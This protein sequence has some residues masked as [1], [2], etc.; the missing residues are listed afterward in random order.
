MISIIPGGL[1]PTMTRREVTTNWLRRLAFGRKFGFIA[2]AA[3]SLVT[4]DGA[5]EIKFDASA[6]MTPMI[7][8]RRHHLL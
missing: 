8:C 7:I 6:I 4:S 2:A 1:Y 3:P 5:V